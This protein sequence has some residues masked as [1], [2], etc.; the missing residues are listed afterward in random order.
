MAFG[1]CD[2]APGWRQLAGD[3]ESGDASADDESVDTV[4]CGDLPK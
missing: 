3:G 1:Y 2:G 4:H